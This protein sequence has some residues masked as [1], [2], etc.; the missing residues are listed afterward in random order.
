MNNRQATYYRQRFLLAFI[1]QINSGVVLT[2]LQMLIFFYSM[3]ESLNFY[4][5]LPYRFGPYSFQLAKDT[6]ILCR[7]GYITLI[8]DT[9]KSVGEYRLDNLFDIEEERGKELLRKILSLYPYFSINSLNHGETVED[10]IKE[11][12]ILSEQTLFTIGYEG[13]SIEA[14]LNLL[15]KNGVKLLCDARK[16]PLSR[17]FGFSKNKLAYITEAIGIKYVHMPELGIESNK[18]RSLTIA[19]D[20]KILFE[21]YA[22]TLTEYTLQLT[23]IYSLLQSYKGIALMCYEK[24]ATMCHRQVIRDF[25]IRTYNVRSIDL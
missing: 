4:E 11:K 2:D 10:F 12:Y 15:I 22:K 7:D 5:F 6:E 20:Y 9:I 21:D 19:D 14:F 24:E 23:Q 1:C 8:N 17:K 3:K 13:K 25:F 16:N 18:R